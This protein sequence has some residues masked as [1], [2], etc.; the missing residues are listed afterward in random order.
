MSPALFL[1]VSLLRKS[2]GRRMSDVSNS[3]KIGGSVGKTMGLIPTM[4]NLDVPL[5]F[6]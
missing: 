1:F 2:S 6:M 4:W 3:C 5:M